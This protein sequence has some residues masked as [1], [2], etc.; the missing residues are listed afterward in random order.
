MVDISNAL[1]IPGFMP[2]K[3]LKQLALWASEYETILEVGSYM[4]RSTRAIADNTKGTILAVDDFQGLRELDTNPQGWEILNAFHTYMEDHLISGK[5]EILNTD[6]ANL[7]GNKAQMWF[8]DGSH[9]YESVQRDIHIGQVAHPHLLCGHDFDADHEDVMRA[10]DNLVRGY[11]II[12]GTS[13]WY[14]C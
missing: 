14:I 9:D 4:G 3:E 11:R 1:Q 6:H 5:V 2:E 10:V 12:P 8:I 7:V 13:L